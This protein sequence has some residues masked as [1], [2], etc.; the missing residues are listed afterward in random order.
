MNTLIDK[1]TETVRARDVSFAGDRLCIALSDGPGP[2]NRARSR[3]TSSRALPNMVASTE[4]ALNTLFP[5]GPGGQ[6]DDGV[7]GGHV[8]VDDGPVERRL[9]GGGG[10]SLQ[11][12]PGR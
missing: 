9:D 12:R 5:G 6:H 3:H 2:S 4:P 7:I 8:A 10:E 1:T 11:E